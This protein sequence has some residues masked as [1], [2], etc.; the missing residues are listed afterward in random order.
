MI[1]KSFLPTPPLRE[2]VR[3]Y[4]IIDFQFNANK[5]VPF[6][7]RS[8]KPEQKIVF[9]IKDLPIIDSPATGTAQKP[10]PV[11]VF[12]HQVDKR[13]IRMSPDNFSPT[14]SVAST[15]KVANDGALA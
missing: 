7:Q 2:F 5:P 3:N 14:R 12:S 11:S 15:N 8:P 13:N 10:P 9:Y 6:K 1:Y 4:T